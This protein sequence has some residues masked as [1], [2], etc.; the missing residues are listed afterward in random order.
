MS[1]FDVNA[2]YL[3]CLF[4]RL[5]LVVWGSS[6]P[7]PRYQLEQ[8]DVAHNRR[9]DLRYIFQAGVQKAQ[10]SRPAAIGPEHGRLRGSLHA[11][12]KERRLCNNG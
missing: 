7:P 4:R 12:G 11:M 8:L 1:T 6:N 5:L 9:I 3:I 10:A 2:F